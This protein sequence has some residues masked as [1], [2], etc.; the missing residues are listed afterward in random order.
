ME[1]TNARPLLP[2]ICRTTEMIR[3]SAASATAITAIIELRIPVI[4]AP[5][6]THATVT[7]SIA[8]PIFT[9]YAFTRSFSSGTPLF[10]L[11][12]RAP[13][14]ANTRTN[15]MP[16]NKVYGVIN[17]NRLPTNSM[18]ASIGTPVRKLLTA[19]P[20][21]SAGNREPIKNNP[22]QVLRHAALSTLLRKSIATP[23]TI[24]P[25]RIRKNAR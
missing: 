16:P 24:S 8:T 9:E 22:S 1:A 7:A 23:R 25:N 17:V 4:R 3:L 19:T 14:N 11:R 12:N 6:T 18:L 10:R 15:T 20:N 2:F 21:N 13:W 5:Y